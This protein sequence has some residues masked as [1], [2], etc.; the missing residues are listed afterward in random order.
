MGV[1]AAIGLMVGTVHSEAAV[2]VGV[3]IGAGLSVGA[4]TFFSSKFLGKK[5]EKNLGE[6]TQ[7]TASVA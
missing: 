4:L 2:A 5:A 1:G 6:S 3:G 7:N